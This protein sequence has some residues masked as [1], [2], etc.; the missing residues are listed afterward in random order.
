VDAEPTKV[1]ADEHVREFGAPRE[2]PS[3]Y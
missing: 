2:R 1:L 3:R